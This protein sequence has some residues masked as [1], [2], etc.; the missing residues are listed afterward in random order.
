MKRALVALLLVAL[1]PACD[2]SRGEKGIGRSEFVATYVALRRATVRGELD[3]ATRDSI[4]EAHGVS[5]GE[6]RDYIEQRA[7]DPE[8]IAD[9]WREIMDSV[10]VRDTLTAEPDSTS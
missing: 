4:L 8:A 7:D 10:A 9:T 2:A 3:A 1:A 5:A 6:L